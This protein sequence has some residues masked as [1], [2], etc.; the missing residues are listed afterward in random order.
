MLNFCGGLDPRKEVILMATS[1]STLAAPLNIWGCHLERQSKTAMEAVPSRFLQYFAA[2]ISCGI[3][4]SV[5]AIDIFEH[6]AFTAMAVVFLT[7]WVVEHE[8]SCRG[9]ITIERT[10]RA[11]KV[12]NI[13]DAAIS[14]YYFRAACGI[15]DI[16]S[17]KAYL[18][19]LAIRLASAISSA[20]TL[21]SGRESHP[22][23]LKSE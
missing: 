16:N 17:Y 3:D 14:I 8:L 15:S 21:L 7:G 11:A 5:A 9:V 22:E 1:A 23:H 12:M 10:L 4:L 20:Y 19:F 13:A 6:N 18:P 2:Y